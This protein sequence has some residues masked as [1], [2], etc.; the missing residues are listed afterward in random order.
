MAWA[1]DPA[2]NELLGANYT[3]DSTTMT[4][5]LSDYASVDSSEA[6]PST[7]DT[8]RVLYGLLQD[9]YSRWASI[10]TEDRPTKMTITR[11]TNVN[12]TAKSAVVTFTVRFTTDDIVTEVADEPA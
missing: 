12:D 5:T 11:T 8:R 10:E 4:F 9:V 7:G 1:N 3:A 6:D 2:T